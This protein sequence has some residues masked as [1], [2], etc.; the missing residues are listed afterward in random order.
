[1]AVKEKESVR[2]ICECGNDTFWLTGVLVQ[3]VCTS[4]GKADPLGI[5]A[6]N[7]NP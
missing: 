4:C 2:M 6:F 7:I 3:A 5:T 1:M